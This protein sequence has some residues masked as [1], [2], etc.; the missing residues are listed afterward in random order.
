MPTYSL[1]VRGGSESL[2]RRL[3]ELRDSRLF[4]MEN[5]FFLNTRV[6]TIDGEKRR[7]ATVY[8]RH[9]S[10]GNERFVAGRAELSSSMT[11]SG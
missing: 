9:A 1:P 6:A 5:K 10:T 3:K 11:A 4:N 7:H 8:V 2:A